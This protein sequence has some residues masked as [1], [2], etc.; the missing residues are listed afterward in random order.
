VFAATR[1]ERVSALVAVGTSARGAAIL[2]PELRESVLEVI[3][4]GWGDGQLLPFWAPSRAHDPGFRRW[5]RRF[6]SATVSAEGARSLV[7]LAAQSDVGPLLS[8]VQAPTLVLHRRDDQLVPVQLGRE[9]ASAIPG[10][11]FVELEGADNLVW[12]GDV[13]SVVDE[14]ERF[15]T[16]EAVSPS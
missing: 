2:T 6:E 1:P 7:E 16:V 4:H 10:A 13:D 8:R 15:L 14:A 3:D 12:A 5:W 9:L 11:R